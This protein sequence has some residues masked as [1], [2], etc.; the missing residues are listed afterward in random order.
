[1][2]AIAI[3]C[4]ALI[5]ISSFGATNKV[6]R[7]YKNDRHLRP[8]PE[9]IAADWEKLGGRLIKPSNGVSILLCDVRKD[10]KFSLEKFAENAAWQLYLPVKVKQVE[11][12]ESCAY[13]FASSQ[14]SADFPA[15]MVVEDN[16]DHPRLAVY[17]EDQI[18]VVNVAKIAGNDAEKK[19]Q[20]EL[21]RGIGFALGGYELPMGVCVLT[22]IRNEEELDGIKNRRLSPMRLNGL[23]KNCEKFNLQANRPVPYVLAVKQGWAPEPTNDVQRAIWKKAHD[24]KERGPV[25]GIKIDPPKK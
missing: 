1:M 24:E 3:A 15:V 14:K 11:M 22:M 13:A 18:A 12:K 8:T 7:T 5:A 21:W 6:E 9:Q 17:P 2:K 19:T 4:T 23:F 10:R 16:P 25:E 20:A